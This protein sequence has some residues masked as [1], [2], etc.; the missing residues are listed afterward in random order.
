MPVDFDAAAGKLMMRINHL[1]DEFLYVVSLPAGV[2]SNPIGL[3]RG[4]MGETH[5]VRFERVGPKVLLV[6]ENT[7]FRALSNDPN[8]RRAV[9][10]SFARSVLWGFKVEK[11]EGDVVTV[12]ATDFFLSDQHG[13]ADRLRATQQGN[14]SVD[15]NRSAIFL[16]RTKS[17]PKNTEVEAILTLETHDHPGALVSGVAPTPQLVTVRE[18]HSLIELPPAGYTPR[19]VDPRVGLFGVEF[20]DYASPFTGPVEKRW[21]ARHRLI[22]K[23]PNAPISEPVEPLVYYVDNGVPEP[24]RS[25]LLEGASWWNAAFEA[26][27]FRNAFQVKV[28]PS[29]ADPMDVRYNM[30]DWVHRST[31]GWSYGESVIDPRTGEI[32]KGNVRLGSLRIRQ[33]VLIGN[34]L[35]PQYEE[36]DD[37]ALS[38]LDA[39]TSPSMLALARIRQLAAH[40]TGHTLG[41]DH[42]MA[43]SS[44]ERASVMDYPAPLVKI[45]NGKLDLSDAYA[46]GVGTY[47]VF[48]IRYAYTQ[49]AP[50]ANEDAE[51]DRIVRSSDILFIKDQDARPVSAAHPLASVWDS[52]GDP[53]NML[54]HEIEVRRIAIDQFG[55]RNLALG[56]PLSSLEEILVPLYLHHRYQLEAAAKSIGGVYYTY[57]VK[58][59]GAIF[60][61]LI[62]QIVPADRQREAMELVMSTLDPPFLQIP[63]RIIDLIPPKAFGYERGTAELFEHRTTPAFDPISAALASADITLGAL[64]DSRRAARMEEFHVE[65]AQYP[66]FTELLDRLMELE[67]RPSGPITRATARL[68]VTRLM[69]LVNSRD[70]DSQVRAEATEAL[71]TMMARIANATADPAEI[72]HRHALRDDIQRFLE[73]PDQPRTQ[74][75][76][77]EVPAGAPIGD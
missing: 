44:H 69:E 26:A 2:G 16:P 41:L 39:A 50:G 54:R 6:E 67:T 38:E 7:R 72:A 31:R 61:P 21:I 70:A 37:R 56:E 5:L 58:E 1:G 4:E 76:P 43:A 28:L 25:A 29:D 66:G 45:T 63:Q 73:R 47:D 59:H 57:A 46:K 48:A 62:R 74:P 13:V 71:R 30:I 75:R 27:G 18:H 33:D 34:G 15:R 11:S 49:F 10:D 53:V 12:D 3:D 52:P 17:F 64:L 24:I 51:L 19:K 42:N 55:L 65:N 77:P 22:K 40:E 32:I 14:Y 35:I 60:P 9:E 23:D 20:N 68:A 36:L 8:E